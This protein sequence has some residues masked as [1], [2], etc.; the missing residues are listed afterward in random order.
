MT[1]QLSAILVL[2]CSALQG[3]STAA[4]EMNT[5]ADFMR[6]RFSGVSL[7][8]DGR[9]V[10]AP[11][12]QTVFSSDEPAIWSLAQAPD[13]KIYV[14]TGHRG[15]LY[16]VDRSGA[17]SLV[18]T[19]PETEIFAITVA[20][21]GTVFAGTSPGGKVY[22]I[23]NGAAEAYYTPPETRYIWALATGKDGALYVGAGDNGRIYRVSGFG[24]RPLYTDAARPSSCQA[25]R[26]SSFQAIRWQLS[27]WI[28]RPW[29]F[30]RPH[31]QQARALPWELHRLFAPRGA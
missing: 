15:R 6:G 16:S 11:R 5:Y 1:R 14:G 18:W 19:A 7:T 4:W 10:L 31:P 23:R 9:V 13:G 21:D 22:R 29:A 26:A 17:S 27:L 3:S 24:Y 25:I 8:R 12:L 20:A 2:A 30:P 28:P